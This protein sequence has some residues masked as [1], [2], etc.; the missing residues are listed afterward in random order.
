MQPQDL[1]GAA[2]WEV[3]STPGPQ[4]ATVRGGEVRPG[5]RVL[6]HPRGGADI[7]DLVLAGR[8][9][10]V[11]GIDHDLSGSVHIAVTLEDDPGRDLGEAR[12][13][14]HRFFFSADEVELIPAPEESRRA[15]RILVAGIG[16]IFLGDDAF[17][18]EVARRLLERPLPAG[19][20]VVDFGIRGLDLAYTLQDRY[21]AVILIDASPRG[22]APGT[23]SLIEPVLGEMGAAQLIEPHGM[24]PVRVLRL[25]IS[26]GAELPV[27]RLVA[28]EPERVEDGGD[29]ELPDGLS[30]PVRAAIEPAVEVVES[31]I[32]EFASLE[33]DR[34]GGDH[35]EG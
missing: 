17:G 35:G 33:N 16:N 11:E 6:L 2:F 7:F 24:D 23:I 26:L 5:S 13:P 34:D 32:A 30:H 3:S 4:V 28:C 25:A 8:V 21:D 15:P 12:M 29:G 31:L 1:S 19:V 22:L 18:V 14:G 10:I 20:E 27:V 9:G